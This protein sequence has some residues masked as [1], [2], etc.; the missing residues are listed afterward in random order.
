MLLTIDVIKIDVLVFGV[1]E[2]DVFG[3]HNFVR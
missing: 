3:A 1:V 2:L